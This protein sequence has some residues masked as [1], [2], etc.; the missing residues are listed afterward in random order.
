MTL[1]SRAGSGVRGANAL[2]LA[3]ALSCVATPLF[4]Q[5]AVPG[6]GVLDLDADSGAAPTDAEIAAL[7]ASADA[8]EEEFAAEEPS[9]MEAAEMAWSEG[10]LEDALGLYESILKSGG[11]EPFDV[12]LAYARIGTVK[13]AL[14]DQT[15]ALSAFRVAAVVNPEFELPSDSGRVASGLYV[16]AREQAE[17]QGERLT[18]K[19]DLPE[20]G[21]SSGSPFSVAVEIPEGFAVFV[22]TISVKVRDTLGGKEWVQKESADSRVVLR[23]PAEAAVAGAKLKL[24]ARAFDAD[25]NA[26]ALQKGRIAVDG[27]RDLGLGGWGNEEKAPI[28]EDDSSGGFFSDN[29]PWLAGGT[30]A[31]VAGVVLFAVLQPADVSVGAPRWQEP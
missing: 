27:V 21:V 4:A 1:F 30:A 7:T 5:D 29:W 17:S 25:G 14:G 6:T 9:Q 24:E 8:T 19:L 16:Q 28:V 26:W 20:D 22:D 12:V 18:L 13:A 10:R 11:L 23:F 3:L 2:A 31:V 15:G